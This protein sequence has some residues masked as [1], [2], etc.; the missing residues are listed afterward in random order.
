MIY[1][2]YIWIMLSVG[3]SIYGVISYWPRDA[4][5]N[6][7]LL[8][9]DISTAVLF[10]PSFYVLFFSIILQVILYYNFNKKNTKIYIFVLYIIDFLLVITIASYWNHIVS[11]LLI[12]FIASTV[13]LVHLFLSILINPILRTKIFS[14]KMQ[15][16][17]K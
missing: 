8:F 11:G 2:Y 3:F 5:G 6:D 14:F 13:G 4:Y 12:A 17:T 10:L 9:N 15:Q 16:S 1:L 7:F